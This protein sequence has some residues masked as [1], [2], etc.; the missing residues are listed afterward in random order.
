MNKVTVIGSI[1]VDTNLRVKRMVRPGETLHASA[2]YTAAGGKGA[3]QAVAAVRSGAGVSFIGAVGSDAPGKEMLHLLKK[4]GID[5]SGIKVINNEATGQAFI[6]VDDNGQNS[7]TIYGGANV[8]F[9]DEDIVNH[10]NL[11]MAC[12]FVIAQFETPVVPTIVGFELARKAGAKTILNPAPAMEKIPEKLLQLTDLIVPNETEAETITGV[13]VIDERSA[14]MAASK[15]HDL[16]VQAVIITLGSNGAFYDFQ[17]RSE[18]IPAFKVKAVDTT[19]AGDTFIGAMTSV[20][21]PDLSNLSES[22]IFANK[23]SSLT[24]QNYGA[25]PSI[26]YKKDISRVK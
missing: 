25:Q 5:T 22:V 9:N 6:M 11:L 12:D 15:F 23:A 1:N 17:G 10:K 14:K 19:G 7:I 3:N 16:G 13:K 2:H 18:M 21:K 20:L 8:K 24:V 4:E 26:P